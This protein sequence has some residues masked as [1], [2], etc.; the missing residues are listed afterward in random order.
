MLVKK[1]RLSGDRK[2]KK[3]QNKGRFFS[4]NFVVVK[5]FYSNTTLPAQIGIVVSKK[6]S[7]KATVRNKIKRQISEVI[8]PLTEKIKQGVEMVIMVRKVPLDFTALQMDIIKIISR[9]NIL[10]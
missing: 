1:N 6:I 9:T 5:V 2:F 10:K 3:I 4:G 7:N 8:F